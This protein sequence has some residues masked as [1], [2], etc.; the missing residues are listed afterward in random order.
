MAKRKDGTYLVTGNLKHFPTQPFIVTAREMLDIL[1][2]KEKS[3]THLQKT[4][5]F[6][7]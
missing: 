3:T 5:C 4:D 1:E 2:G 7:P 6:V